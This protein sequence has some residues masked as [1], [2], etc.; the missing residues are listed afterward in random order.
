MK[1][2]REL[3]RTWSARRGAY[4]ILYASGDLDAVPGEHTADRLDPEAV[5][6]TV[7]EGHY[8]GSRESSSRAKN[9]LP[10]ARS[11]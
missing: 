10:P 3:E 6:V 9:E 11:R 4:R 7:D 1:L 2:Q 8:Q 5:L